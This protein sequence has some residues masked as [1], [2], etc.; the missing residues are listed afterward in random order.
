MFLFPSLW[1]GL[2]VTL[3]EAQ[4]AGLPCLVSDRITTDADISNL[5]HRLSIDDVSKGQIWHYHHKA[6]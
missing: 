4:A 2:P 3:V 5:I 6:A 1:E